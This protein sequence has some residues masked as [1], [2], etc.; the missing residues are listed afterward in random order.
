MCGELIDHLESRDLLQGRFT[1]LKCVNIGDGK[2]RGNFSIILVA[3]DI[4]EDELVAIK[5]F[6]PNFMNDVAY[7]FPIISFTELAS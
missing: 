6:D 7:L 3:K 2:R 4:L 5:F 1:N